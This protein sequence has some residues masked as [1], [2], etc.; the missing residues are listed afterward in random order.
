[1]TVMTSVQITSPGGP[2]KIAHGPVPAPKPNTVRIKVQACGI[3][4]SVGG[5][6]ALFGQKQR[7]LRPPGNETVGVKGS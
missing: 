6:T 1:M 5:P 7:T 3:C 2:L 4:H